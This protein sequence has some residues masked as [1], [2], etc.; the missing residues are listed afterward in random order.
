MARG[1]RVLGVI[2]AGLAIAVVGLGAG[3]YV[4]YVGGGKFRGH[5]ISI[6][7]WKVM[8]PAFDGKDPI[9]VLVLGLDQADKLEPHGSQRSDSIMLL[10]IDIKH[11][12]V[13]G[14]SVPRDTLADIPGRARQQKINAAYALGKAPLAL[15]AIHELTGVPIDYYL[16]SQVYGFKKMVDLV[17]GIDLD[18]EKDMNYDDNWQ[19]LHIHLKKGFQHLDGPHAM[20]YVRFRHDATGDIGRMQRQQKFLRAVAKQVFTLRNLPRLPAVV[21]AA[22]SVVQTNMDTPDLIYLANT[23]R[24]IKPE[25]IHL[26]TMPEHPQMIHGISYLIADEDAAHA[27]IARLFDLSGPAVAATVRVLNG[28]GRRG[29]ASSVARLLEQNGFKIASLGNAD[30]ASYDTSQILY[31][32]EDQE[33]AQAISN[34]LGAGQVEPAPPLGHSRRDRVAHPPADITVIIGQDYQGDAVAGGRQ[35]S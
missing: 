6:G 25:D 33:G 13:Q 32:P 35:N 16:V 4:R 9:N 24:G 28:T 34:L 21:R 20:Q 23:L 11:K 2:V 12:R 17:G 30:S 1:V 18:V 29:L 27:Q 3:T 15:D 31:Q 26:E 10:H 8:H 19:D 14:L 5:V 22:R 7:G